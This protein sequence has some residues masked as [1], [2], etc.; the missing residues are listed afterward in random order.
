ML[1]AQWK[2]YCREHIIAKHPG[3]KLLI[4]KFIWVQI[5]AISLYRHRFHGFVPFFLLRAVGEVP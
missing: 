5:V 3:L 1:G 2:T 4:C